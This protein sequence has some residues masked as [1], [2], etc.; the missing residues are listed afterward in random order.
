MSE[1]TRSDAATLDAPTESST[2]D[3]ASP[4]VYEK[5]PDG[6]VVVTMFM[7][8]KGFDFLQR[9][10]RDADGVE[11]K[12]VIGRALVV[13]HDALEAIR[14]G[15]AVGVASDPEKLEVQFIDL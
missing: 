9:L 12:D 3:A 11:L 5:N 14:E 7:S 15:K 10:T 4:V 6:S 1:T 2:D 8:E 13:Y